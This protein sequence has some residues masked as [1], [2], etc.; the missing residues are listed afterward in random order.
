[1]VLSNSDPFSPEKDR[2]SP[3][4]GLRFSKEVV[5]DKFTQALLAGEAKIREARI[6]VFAGLG[7]TSCRECELFNLMRDPLAWAREAQNLSPQAVEAY[8][9]RYVGRIESA[10][11][12]KCGGLI[13]RTEAL[14]V[15]QLSELPT[16]EDD[17]ALLGQVLGET[18]VKRCGLDVPSPRPMPSN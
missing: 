9:D 11:E 6:R 13:V 17:P 4:S 5:P 15:E 10:G 3:W 16:K 1:M 8:V 18:K 14:V 12:G 2:R 7:N